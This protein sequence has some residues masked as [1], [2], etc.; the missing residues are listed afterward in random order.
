VR[1]GRDG[2]EAVLPLPPMTAF[3]QTA[4]RKMIP[5]LRANIDKGVA[6]VRR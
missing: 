4:L 3:E 5:E 2:V 6:F 1:L